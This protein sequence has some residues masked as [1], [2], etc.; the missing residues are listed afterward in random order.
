[1]H[2]A[3]ALLTTPLCALQSHCSSHP[4]QEAKPASPEEKRQEEA[5]EEEEEEEDND[6]EE[7]LLEEEE[8]SEVPFR[9][10]LTAFNGILTAF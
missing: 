4:H 6:A 7:V 2:T 1:M 10:I 5:R 9:A 3:I 8:L